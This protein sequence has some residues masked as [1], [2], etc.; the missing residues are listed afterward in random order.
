[1][2]ECGLETKN[3]GLIPINSNVYLTEASKAMLSSSG[4]VRHSNLCVCKLL[5]LKKVISLKYSLALI[6]SYSKI[7]PTQLT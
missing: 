7:W 4:I 1:M 3:A 2:C 6:I 5:T